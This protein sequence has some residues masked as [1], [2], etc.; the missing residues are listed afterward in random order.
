VAA[1]P[2]LGTQD[3][4]KRQFNIDFAWKTCHS[5][6]I[7]KGMKAQT[8]K[9]RGYQPTPAEVE[10]LVTLLADEDQA[11]RTSIRNRILSYGRTACVWLHPYTLSSDPVVRRRTREIVRF[12]SRRDS[13]EQFLGFCQNSGEELDLELATGL[14]AQTEYPEINPEGYQALYDEWAGELKR[15]IDFREEPHQFLKVINAY[16][17][18]QLGFRGSEHYNYQP[19]CSYLNKVIDQRNGNP[20]SLCTIYLFLARRLCLPV[21]GIGLPGHFICRF[22]TTTCEIYLDVFRGGRFLTRADCI[23]FLVERCHGVNQGFLAPVSGR[24]ML[25]R[26]C[27]NLHQTYSQL[28]LTEEAARVQRYLIALAR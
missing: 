28:D 11:I 24:R 16:L 9:P 14:L 19:E 7:Q 2:S 10:A 3:P 13:D 17:F 12:I 5:R 18:D 20:I 22:Q 23:R 27:A 21:T 1:I 6:F 8:P 4:S 25:S 15:R 26:M